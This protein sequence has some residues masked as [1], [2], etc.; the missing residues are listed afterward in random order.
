MSNNT[1]QSESNPVVFFDVALG[2]KSFSFS[3]FSF[4]LLASYLANV[5]SYAQHHM[6]TTLVS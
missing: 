3:F 2:G 5:I 1:R 4:R 6:D